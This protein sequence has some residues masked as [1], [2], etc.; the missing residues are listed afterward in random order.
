[1]KRLRVGVF[2]KGNSY[3]AHTLV[4]GNAQLQAA[5]YLEDVPKK[6]QKKYEGVKPVKLVLTIPQNKKQS[7]NHGKQPSNDAQ[8]PSNDV[9]QPSNDGK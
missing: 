6:E 9:Q 4:E 1:M 8:Q 3:Q 2:H 5:G 7:V